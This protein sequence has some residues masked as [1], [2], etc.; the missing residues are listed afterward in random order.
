ME[1]NGEL[2]LSLSL[3]GTSQLMLDRVAQ[4]D[5]LSI[6]LAGLVPLS[7]TD[8]TGDNDFSL[9]TLISFAAIKVALWLIVLFIRR[10]RCVRVCITVFFNTRHAR[11]QT[12]LMLT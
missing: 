12:L 9:M 5:Q 2:A 8:K 10:Q 3:N 4:G 11:D 7:F 6:K 1:N